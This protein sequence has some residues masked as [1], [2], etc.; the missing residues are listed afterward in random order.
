MPPVHPDARPL[1]SAGTIQW[2]LSDPC[3]ELLLLL[4]VL[5]LQPSG[6]TYSNRVS[7]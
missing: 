1:V 2:A 5:P 3:A 7:A 4:A 6:V